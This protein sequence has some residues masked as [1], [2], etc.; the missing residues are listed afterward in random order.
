MTNKELK[1]LK[2]ALPLIQK[3]LKNEEDKDYLFILARKHNLKVKF[4]T[5]WIDERLSDRSTSYACGYVDATQGI[6]IKP[7]DLPSIINEC[8]NRLDLMNKKAERE[9]EKLF[10]Y[11]QYLRCTND[12]R[13]SPQPYV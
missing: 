4:I 5:E 1:L 11:I 8:E 7:Y 2:D 9:Q 13:T 3:A 6:A 12:Q 10:N